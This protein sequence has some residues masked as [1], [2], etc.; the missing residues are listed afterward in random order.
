MEA[1]PPLEA[2]NNQHASARDAE[3][4]FTAYYVG[5]VEDKR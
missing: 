1:N 5:E 3:G 2:G 4:V